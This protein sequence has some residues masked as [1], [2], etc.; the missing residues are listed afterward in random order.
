MK[1]EKICSWYMIIS[2]MN[3]PEGY[4]KNCQ[5]CDGYHT[6]CED[7]AP[8]SIIMNSQRKK[9]LEDAKITGVPSKILE[10]SLEFFCRANGKS[11]ISCGWYN[12]KHC[13]RACK[14][15]AKK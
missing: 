4:F 2:S 8:Q 1:D 15:Y 3:N 10:S 5:I 12:T 11:I 9:T 14:F 7:Y 6:Y 13:L